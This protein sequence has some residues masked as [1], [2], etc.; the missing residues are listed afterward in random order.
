MLNETLSGDWTQTDVT[1]FLERCV[2]ED[3]EK[4]GADSKFYFVQNCKIQF[5][6]AVDTSTGIDVIDF[7]IEKEG[8]IEDFPILNLY[9]WQ[10]R[11]TMRGITT[12]T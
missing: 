5:L 9:T 12:R 7:L 11:Y 1:Y 3:I 4:N 8:K 6:Y 2:K 10:W